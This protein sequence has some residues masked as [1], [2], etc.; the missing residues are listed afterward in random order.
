MLLREGR[1]SAVDASGVM[2]DDDQCSSI[3]LYPFHIE[4][5]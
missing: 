3:L 5:K 4:K 2:T 1:E